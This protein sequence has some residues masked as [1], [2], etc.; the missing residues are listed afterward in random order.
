MIRSSGRWSVIVA[1]HSRCDQKTCAFQL[2]FVLSS[3]FGCAFST[4]LVK[5]GKS[6]YVVHW[7]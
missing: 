1:S 3:S 6:R 4:F 5:V 7:L 2:T